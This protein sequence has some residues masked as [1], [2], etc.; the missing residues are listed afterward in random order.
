MPDPTIPLTGYSG[1]AQLL[2]GSF[3]QL[4]EDVVGFLPNV[5]T[6]QFNPETISRSLTPWNPM[7]V[8]Q[9][10]RG[11]QAPTVQP[12]DVP[13]KFSGFEL[14]FDATD[15][16]AAGNPV[17]DQFGVEPQLAA[18]RKLTQATRG[19]LGDLTA[20]FKDLAGLGGAEAER[21]TV[22]PVLLVLGK[23][24]ILPV[25]ITS[26]SVEENLMSPQLYPIMATVSLDM[27]VMTPDVF[28]CQTSRAAVIAIGAYELT[29]LQEDA[30][31]VLNLA[32]LPNPISSL[33]P[34]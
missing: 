3:V 23:R 13:E 8:D 21:P 20:S 11:S 6:F 30:A 25:R 2:R 27:E 17:A 4:I 26:F 24:V 29:R 34:L 9:A 15:G 22:A 10:D 1:A 7:D 31:A 14:Q 28:R 12:F 19:L 18:M 16:M 33:L 32:N 5:V